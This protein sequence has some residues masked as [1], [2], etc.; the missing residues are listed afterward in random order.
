MRRFL[1]VIGWCACVVAFIALAG[2]VTAF[3][4]YSRYQTR[5]AKYD[6]AQLRALPERS[7]IVDA[8]G[9][10]YTYLDG[11]NRLIV[12]LDKVPKAFLDALLAREDSRFWNHRGV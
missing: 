11:E 3:V 12:P 2:V 4:F 5:A 10:I 8:N 9:E 6:L 7:A 1:T